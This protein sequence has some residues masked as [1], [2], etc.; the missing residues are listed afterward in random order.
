MSEPPADGLAHRI[1]TRMAEF[2]A[3][4]HEATAAAPRG[5]A[6]V[7][8]CVVGAGPDA[9]VVLIRRAAQGLNAGQWAFPGGRSE[10]GESA[11]RTALREAREEIG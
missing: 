4:R 9:H 3:L 2:A 8:I 1:R 5:T 6:A 10:D 7:A 11:E